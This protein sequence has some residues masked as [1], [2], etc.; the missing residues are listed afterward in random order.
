MLIW[1][2]DETRAYLDYN[3]DRVNNFINNMLQWYNYYP[4]II[5]NDLGLCIDSIWWENRRFLSIVEADGVIDFGGNYRTR[6]GS[7][8]DLFY[9]G[10]KSAFTPITNPSTR[11]NSGAYTGINIYNISQIDTIMRFDVLLESRLRGFPKF[12]NHSQF[13]PVLADIDGDG[14]EEIFISGQQHIVAMKHDGSPIIKP[15]PGEEIFDSS[16]VTY[17]D[18]LNTVGFVVDTLRSIVS[19]GSDENIISP[20]MVYDLDAD[21]VF[22][23]AVATNADSVYVWHVLDSDNNGRAD[24]NYAFSF[25][26]SIV[27]GPVAVGIGEDGTADIGVGGKGGYR[28]PGI[29]VQTDDAIVTHI[30]VGDLPNRTPYLLISQTATDGSP[31]FKIMAYGVGP[32]LLKFEDVTAAGFTAA[33]LDG[34]NG[35]DFV[36][37]SSDGKLFIILSQSSDE[38]KY[39]VNEIKVCDSLVG[40]VVTAALDPTLPYYQIIFT[41]NNKVYVYNHNGTPFENYP[42]DIDI[43]I[44]TGMIQTTPIVADV[45]ADGS[46]DIVVGT[47]FGELFAF[48]TDG[49]Q[50][51]DFPRF[52]GSWRNI[53]SAVFPG[54][55]A[56]NY[57]GMLYTISHDN[58]LYGHPIGSRT[59]GEEQTWRQYGRSA[60]SFNFRGGELIPPSK[61]AGESLIVSCYNYPNPAEEFTNIRYRLQKQGTVNIQV[62]DLS[63]RLVYE[64]DST[65]GDVPSEYRWNLDGYPSGV[66][67]CRLEAKSEDSSDVKTMKIAVVR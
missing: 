1:H 5:P 57:S 2:V 10:N 66:Y 4:C 25:D 46:P 39:D 54:T 65:G 31:A 32:G 67:I 49:W 17:G 42:Q 58:R 45:D 47:D 64:D 35:I 6:F 26:D 61:L 29:N 18:T 19:V 36:V 63:G 7:P 21:G 38:V 23:V 16:M 28:G 3:L 59:L 8:F 34:E 40:G 30:S 37:T 22:E 15:R 53:G 48:R 14:K 27:V 44:P 20:P 41:G 50:A 9:D 51:T 62:Y 52:A 33:D 43:H 60:S 12:V 55:S 24:F 13:P 56:N 11:S